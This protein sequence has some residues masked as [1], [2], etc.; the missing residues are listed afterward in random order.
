MAS[1]SVLQIPEDQGTPM[2]RTINSPPTCYEFTY[3]V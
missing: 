2:F 1:P 3:E